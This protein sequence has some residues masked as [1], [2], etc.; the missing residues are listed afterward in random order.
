M[1]STSTIA[2]FSC[3]TME[4]FEAL[5][6]RE[7]YTLLQCKHCGARFWWPMLYD[8]PDQ[9]RG[10]VTYDESIC[11]I[12]EKRHELGIAW[13][14]KYR[15]TSRTLLDIACRGGAFVK[16]AEQAG[17]EAWG[18]DAEADVIAVAK[19][20]HGLKNLHAATLRE[21]ADKPGLKGYFDIISLFEILEHVTYPQV[22]FETAKGLLAP[23]GAIVLSIPNYDTLGGYPR[24]NDAPY[25]WALWNEKTIRGFLERHGFRIAVLQHIDASPRQ[26]ANFFHRT[27]PNKTEEQ[28]ASSVFSYPKPSP[29]KSAMKKLFA[30]ALGLIN[31]AGLSPTIF[32]AAE[33]VS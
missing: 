13:I 32:V 9:P 26:F 14:K 7:D 18:I 8:H 2:C 15:P 30:P 10:P 12:F 1:T 28:M 25:Q 3:E 16:A 20:V 6:H 11:K 33:L 31:A 23:G 29:V 22:F 19:K 5:R 27:Q 17:I 24:E 21:F 4:E